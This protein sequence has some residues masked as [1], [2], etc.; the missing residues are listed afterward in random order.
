[1]STEPVKPRTV[2]TY[3]SAEDKQ[4][5]LARLTADHLCLAVVP[6]ADLEKTVVALDAGGDV[7]TY[8]LSDT[9]TE[10]ATFQLAERK[11]WDEL[12]DALLERFGPG[13]ERSAK[14][15]PSWFA[16][17]WPLGVIV[18]AALVTWWMHYEASRIAAGEHLQA[19]GSGRAKAVT[20]V[21]HLVEGWIGTT[22]VLILGGLAVLVGFL[23]L[24]YALAYPGVHVTLR[25]RERP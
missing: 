3:P 18:V 5:T 11:D 22:G 12:S 16:A 25:P 9:K 1:M 17:L 15:N 10:T 23:W 14:K 2:W 7:V 6:A 4:P 21:M 8:K 24:G 20:A 13:W 19:T